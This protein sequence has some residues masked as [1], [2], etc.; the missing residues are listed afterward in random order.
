MK[1]IIAEVIELEEKEFVDGL[2]DVEISWRYLHNT[3]TLTGF[4]DVFNLPRQV[5]YKKK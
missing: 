5:R 3:K 4:S 1:G 2:T